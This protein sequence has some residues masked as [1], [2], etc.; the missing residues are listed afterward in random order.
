MLV[1]RAFHCALV[2]LFRGVSAYANQ[3]P[4]NVCNVCSPVV[5]I[6]SIKCAYY[7]PWHIYYEEEPLSFVCTTVCRV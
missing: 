3:V 5:S 1:E 4:F 7:F 2:V 6:R